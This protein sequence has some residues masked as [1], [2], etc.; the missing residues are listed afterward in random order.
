MIHIVQGKHSGIKLLDGNPVSTISALLDSG[1]ALGEPQTLNQNAS[2][3]F[4]GSKVYGMGFVLEPEEASALIAKDSRN[5]DI[6]FPFLN[7]ENLNTRPDQSPSRYVINFFDWPLEKAEQYS[8]CMA[9]VREKVYPER[10]QQ[11]REIR[12][13]YWWRYG[14][15]APGLYRAI[16]PLRR[17]LIVAQTSKTLA[18]SRVNVRLCFR[19]TLALLITRPLCLLRACESPAS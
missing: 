12:K 2:K 10:M 19:M 18:W 14:E 16:A 11:N 5:V 13:R 6:I 15:I 3:S 7:G 9:L 4:M 1:S 17:I 8:D